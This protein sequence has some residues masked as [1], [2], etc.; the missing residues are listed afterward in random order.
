VPLD[1]ATGI[2]TL[3]NMIESSILS[4]NRVLVRDLAS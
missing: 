1:E 2:D 4:P 3:G